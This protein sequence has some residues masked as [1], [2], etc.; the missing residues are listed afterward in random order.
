LT[1]EEK[2]INKM[3][4]GI[5]IKVEHAICGVKRFRIVSDILRSK[6]NNFDDKVMVIS[7]G[8]WNYHLLCD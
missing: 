1:D 4:S 3:I 8:L 6:R 2:T 7:C 5:R